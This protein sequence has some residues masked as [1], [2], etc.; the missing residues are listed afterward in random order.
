MNS[1][2]IAAFALN[3]TT[4]TLSE[5]SGSP[6]AS[7][8]RYHAGD[9]WKISAS[10]PVRGNQRCLNPCSWLAAWYALGEVI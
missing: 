7:A 8:P 9:S 2:E 10:S 3:V 5:I 1:N 6:F 4:G